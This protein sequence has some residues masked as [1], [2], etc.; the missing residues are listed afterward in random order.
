M[1]VILVITLVANSGGEKTTTP[2]QSTPQVTGT[3]SQSSPSAEPTP[4]AIP[5]IRLSGQGKKA[6]Q[7]FTV[8]DGLAVFRS[9]CSSCSANFIVTLLDSSGRTKDLLVNTI[10]AYDGSKAEGLSAGSYRLNITGDAAW[11]VTITQPRNQPAVALPQTYEGEGDQ[12]RGPFDADHAVEV[13]G[14]NTGRGNFIVVVL[15][16]EG[17]TQDLAFNEIG[18]FNGSTVSQMFGGGPYY[19]NVTSDGTWTLRLSKP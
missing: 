10:G 6:T 8:T 13:Q 4:T 11:S 2:T 3:T 1:V 14:A 7:S 16:A 15:D 19:I 17:G 18:T 5:A 9:T 12:V